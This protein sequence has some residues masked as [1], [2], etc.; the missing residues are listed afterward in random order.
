MSDKVI[1]VLADTEALGRDWVR[2]NVRVINSSNLKKMVGVEA[3]YIV[4]A[5]GTAPEE[6]VQYAKTRVR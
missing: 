6:M 1:L 2:R 4:N 3:Q 5:W